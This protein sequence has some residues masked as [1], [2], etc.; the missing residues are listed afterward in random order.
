M[1]LRD[2]SSRRVKIRAV[3]P[4]DRERIATAF[5]ALDPKSVYRRFFALKKALSERELHWVT[6]PDGC[7]Q[8]VLVATVHRDG[9]ESI[10]ALGQ[11]VR[12]G[13]SAH[14]AFIVA[15]DYQGRGIA[16]RMFHRLSHIARAHGIARLEADVLAENGAMLSVFRH[17]KLPISESLDDGVVHVTLSLDDCGH[18]NRGWAGALRFLIPSARFLGSHLRFFQF[19]S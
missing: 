12:A 6:A 2:A 1:T 11:Y 5:R 19:M 10:V 18:A 17:S 15:D 14:V 13:D 4:D 7:R 9:R 3:R 8:V 16:G